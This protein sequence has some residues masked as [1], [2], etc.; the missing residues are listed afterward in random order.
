MDLFKLDPGLF[1]WTWI[2]FGLLFVL[3]WK[4]VFPGLFGAINSRERKIRES[5]NKAEQIEQRLAEIEAEHGKVIQRARDEA[6][7][8]LRQTR[9]DAEGIKTRMLE[10]AEA[11]ISELHSQAAASI[12]TERAA[13]IE[14]L[15]SEIADLVLSVS[16]KLVDQTYS[17]DADRNR[18]EELIKSL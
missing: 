5:V 10:K 16:E 3:L 8:I 15:R 7:E 4:F 6:D 12:S 13:A 9:K 1:L 11:E 17:A 2:T 14:S 18:V